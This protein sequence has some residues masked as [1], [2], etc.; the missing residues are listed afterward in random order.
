[1]FYNANYIMIYMCSNKISIILFLL[2]VYAVINIMDE[3][4]TKI[5]YFVR[6]Q[7]SLWCH[8]HLFQDRAVSQN[9]YRY[10]IFSLVTYVLFWF[11]FYL[12]SARNFFL[13]WIAVMIT[14]VHFNAK[15]ANWETPPQLHFKYNFNNFT[16]SGN[17]N[18]IYIA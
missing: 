17:L 16:F 6:N 8:D 2:F 15:F 11:K 5:R 10:P 14:N 1:M 3:I 4:Y 12:I 9:K 18:Q 13:T 7:L